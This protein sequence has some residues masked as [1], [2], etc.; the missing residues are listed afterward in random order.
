V[1]FLSN[2][3]PYLESPV[4]GLL[5]KTQWHITL[6]ARDFFRRELM[7][8]ILTFRR[9]EEIVEREVAVD[10]LQKSW[11]AFAPR[12]VYGLSQRI[13]NSSG[14]VVAA[15]AGQLMV[16]VLE[17]LKLDIGGDP[18][19]VPSTFDELTA[20]GTW[21]THDNAGDTV[22]LVDVTVAPDYRGA[23]LFA[24]F[25]Q[26]AQNHFE[27]PSGVILTYSPLFPNQRRYWVVKKHERLGAK[28]TKELPRSRPGLTMTVE[29]DELAAEDVGITAYAA[30]RAGNTR[31]AD[32]IR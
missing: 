11:K 32:S 26:F 10:I 6:P 17:A 7:E 29:G 5:T 1:V 22:V 27:S 14:Y 20:D 19:K 9:G 28:L 4:Q 21:S 31:R 15:Y 24:S 18:E 12:D 30:A 3:S 2:S 13:A 23:G 16:G 25:V 8:T